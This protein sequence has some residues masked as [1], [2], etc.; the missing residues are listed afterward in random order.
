MQKKKTLSCSQDNVFLMVFQW[1]LANRVS[2]TFSLENR[3]RSSQYL[4]EQTLED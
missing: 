4:S 2:A 3:G 1:P